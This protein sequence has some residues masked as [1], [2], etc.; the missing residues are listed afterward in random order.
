[1]DRSLPLG[2][3]ISLTTFDFHCLSLYD[4]WA[5]KCNVF[6]GSFQG[7]SLL[8]IWA[9]FAKWWDLLDLSKK[10]KAFGYGLYM[11]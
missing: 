7:P 10:K 3:A 1:M 11:P 6:Q 9:I 8:I 5:L 2:N 4:L